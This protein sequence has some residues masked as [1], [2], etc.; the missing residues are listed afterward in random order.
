MSDDVDLLLQHVRS[1]RRALDSCRRVVQK[2]VDLDSPQK[3]DLSRFFLYADLNEAAT[4]LGLI[5]KIIHTLRD[6]SAKQLVHAKALQPGERRERIIDPAS[7][8]GMLWQQRIELTPELTVLTKALYEWLYHIRED[9]QSEPTLK[10]AVPAPLWSELGRYCN[11][12]NSL[13]TH[14]SG[15]KLHAGVGV[16]F[17]RDFSK[18]EIM[19]VP[20]RGLP[21]S[22]VKKLAALYDE[23][24]LYLNVAE[25]SQENHIERMG[26][27][28]R[29]LAQF[30]GDLQ[31]E[32]KTFMNHYGAISDTPEELAAFLDKLTSAIA[33]HLSK[34][35][36]HPVH[37]RNS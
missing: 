17:M 21:E 29:R 10:T 4:L 37:S 13:V 22:A 26:I 8:D 14:K 33:A 2:A 7:E 12:R 6:I 25:R 20:F 24:K 11:F 36:C 30:P 28:Y 35:V 31:S 32:V 1:I 15:R 3:R 23:A 5:Y 18:F 16:R 19:L 9:L 34:N 27:L